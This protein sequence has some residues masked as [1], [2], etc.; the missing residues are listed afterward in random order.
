MLL[1]EEKAEK[2][3][4]SLE[5]A[6]QEKTE[7]TLRG[8]GSKHIPKRDRKRGFL[9]TEGIMQNLPQLREPLSWVRADLEA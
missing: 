7:I 4:N 1:E 6:A 5:R 3:M 8:K 9:G 2:V